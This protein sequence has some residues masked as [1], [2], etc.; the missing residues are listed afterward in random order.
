MPVIKILPQT[1]INQI[2]AGEV[3]ERPA[4]VLKE[5]VENALDAE[6]TQIDVVVKGGGQSYLQVKDNGVGMLPE[7]LELSVQRHT[8][9]KIVGKNLLDIH[10]FGFR[11]E[12]LSSV[13]SVSRLEIASRSR[14]SVLGWV[15]SIENGLTIRNEPMAMGVGT[16][17]T[18][19]D[20]FFSTPARLKFLKAASAELTACLQQMRLLALANPYAGMTLRK[21]EKC[22]LDVPQVSPTVPS[23]A[24]L[25]QRI[26]FILGEEFYENS[27]CLQASEDSLSCW[28]RLGLPTYHGRA[29]QY[30][31]VNQ[32]PIKDKN[33]LTAVKI[34]Y[35]NVL[36]PGE[37]PS[38]ILFLTLPP[39]EVDMNV[40][41][42]KTEVRFRKPSTVK[43]FLI[44]TLQTTLE[45]SQK[46][47]SLLGYKFLQHLHLGDDAASTEGL[48]SESPEILDSS[49][50]PARFFL[51]NNTA[52][53]EPKALPLDFSTW[54][55]NS[56]A[57]AIVP[58]RDEFVD[59]DETEELYPVLA[60]SIS[61]ADTPRR[62]RKAK[63]SDQP[64]TSCQPFSLGV[65]K[66]QL[67]NS[68]ILAQ[69]EDEMILVDQHAA[70]ERILYE[71][72]EK[73]LVCH[74]EGYICSLW[75]KHSLLFP[76]EIPLTSLEE[77]DAEDLS[78]Y[79]QRLGFDNF[80]KENIM[81]VTSLPQIC[82]ALDAQALIEANLLEW[83]N[84]QNQAISKS[85]LLAA[86]HH[87]FATYAC[88]HSV[89]ANHPL[90]LEEMNALLRQME[91][92]H[93]SGQCNHGRPT[94]IRL[95]RREIERLF[96]RKS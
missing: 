33:L 46:T 30:L 65:A 24:A 55:K 61:A 56:A 12:A 37:Q 35:Q 17:V 67:F 49:P 2:A 53:S 48:P 95:S 83:Q 78:L 88:H 15:L 23:P 10:T 50:P 28:G 52:A 25:D 13:G 44:S 85:E 84:E 75:P 39:H 86:V 58:H 74:E 72:L 11:G 14:D 42:A 59:D 90:N 26:L 91:A 45:K 80:I 40:H 41:P 54:R 63:A 19:R 70:H 1:L 16:T 82:Q 77:V 64:F 21:P 9:S 92:T 47:P 20:L 38:F 31:F 18:V 29:G 36:I 87:L 81:H 7:D 51:A 71:S 89:R 76:L 8:T 32:R 69:N 96:E 5:L 93:R 27:L 34:A 62:N 43:S 68:F 6:S 4:S 66:A 3:I 94:F 73:N 57:E 79:F 22:L 60:S